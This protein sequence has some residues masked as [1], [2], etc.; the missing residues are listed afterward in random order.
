MID[1]DDG[2]AE[3]GARGAGVTLGPSRNPPASVELAFFPSSTT[4]NTMAPGLICPASRV[5]T[6]T[7]PNRCNVAALT[8]TVNIFQDDLFNQL[9]FTPHGVCFVSKI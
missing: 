9:F 7:H 5:H 8:V 4:V 2:D 3:G 6:H 1:G